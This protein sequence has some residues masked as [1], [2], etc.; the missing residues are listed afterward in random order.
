MRVYTSKQLK[1]LSKK[2]L[3][4]KLDMVNGSIYLT[5]EEIIANRDMIQLFLNNGVKYT[6]KEVLEDIAAGSADIDDIIG[7]NLH[8][9]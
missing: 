2:E 7:K 6:T 3:Q 1:G 4:L 5:D 8:I 9:K